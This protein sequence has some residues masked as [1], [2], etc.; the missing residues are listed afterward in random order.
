MD[1]VL[2]AEYSNHVNT[3]NWFMLTIACQVVHFLF[4][5]ESLVLLCFVC[6]YLLP[7]FLYLPFVITLI[8]SICVWLSLRPLVSFGALDFF[9][10]S[11]NLLKF[12]Y[13]Q[14][15]HLFLQIKN[16]VRLIFTISDSEVFHHEMAAA[17]GY[18]SQAI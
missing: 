4:Y 5:F 9:S 12:K 14:M 7:L 2:S 11:L 15:K 1:D 18:F 16:N 8:C 3:D 6:M 17:W 13:T 10:F